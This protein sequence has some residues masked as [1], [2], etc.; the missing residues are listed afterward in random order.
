MGGLDPATAMG[1]MNPM[2]MMNGG[3]NPMMMGM[4]AGGGMMAG[5]NAQQQLALMQ[6]Q[7]QNANLMGLNGVSLQGMNGLQ[8]GMNLQG[9]GAMGGGGI[10]ALPNMMLAS[11][12]GQGAG[13]PLNDARLREQQQILVQLQQA[14]ASASSGLNSSSMGNNNL[15]NT[16]NQALKNN[17]GLNGLQGSAHILTNDQGNLYTGGNAQFMANAAA[18]NNAQALLQMQQAA[19]MSGLGSFPQAANGAAAPGDNNGLDAAN[20]RSFLNQQ[21]SMFAGGNPPAAAAAK[22]DA[23][24]MMAQGKT[25]A[26][27]GTSEMSNLPQG[28]PG[29]LPQGL[30]YEQFF[31]LNGVANGASAAA[32]TAAAGAEAQQQL[33]SRSGNA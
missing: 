20:F 12:A 9:I 11:Q 27:P 26:A 16:T 28:L 8:Q 24:T 7:Q 14:H 13:N 10:N 5:L 17:F 33:L 30:S 22:G 23:A 4:A 31:Q 21:I 19:A 25:N 2:M 6:Q 29:N 1:L 32:A 15:S 18:G 3:M